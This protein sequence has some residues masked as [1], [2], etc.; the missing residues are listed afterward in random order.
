M[1][2]RLSAIE[3]QA[4]CCFGLS[5]TGVCAGQGRGA[6]D[7]I[8]TRT[9]LRARRFK[10]AHPLF[11][12][13]RGRPVQNAESVVG[14]WQTVTN[15]RVLQLLMQLGSLASDTYASGREARLEQIEHTFN[16]GMC[17]IES[18]L[19]FGEAAHGAGPSLLGAAQSPWRARPVAQPRAGVEEELGLLARPRRVR[20]GSAS[21]TGHRRVVGAGHAPACRARRRTS[22]SLIV[23]PNFS[24]LLVVARNPFIPWVL[25]ALWVARCCYSAPEV[26]C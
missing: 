11:A 13:G 25:S 26:A 1:T 17:G 2:D 6:R 22:N 16:C 23:G 24:M 14:M 3:A 10:F 15:Y 20:P 19:P 21:A 8:R 12:V 9:P 18:S 5:P 4:W 7:G